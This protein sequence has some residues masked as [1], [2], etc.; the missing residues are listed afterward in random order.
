MDTSAILFQGRLTEQD[1]DVSINSRSTRR[2]DPSIEHAIDVLWDKALIQAKEHGF[3]LWDSG[4]YRVQACTF[5]N[6]RL[7]LALGHI[8]FKTGRMIQDIPNIQNMDEAYFPNSLSVV[9]IIKTADNRYLIGR[10]SS[11]YTTNKGQYKLIGGG[12]I[13]DEGEIHT[14]HDLFT[15]LTKELREEAGITQ[16][17]I[18]TMT[19]THIVRT[20]K[21]QIAIIFYLSLALDARDCLHQFKQEN[22][23]ELASLLCVP[24]HRLLYYLRHMHEYEEHFTPAISY[25]M[26]L[27]T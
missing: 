9:G 11:M 27:T 13:Q 7:Q 18:K 26:N 8:R 1:I 19:L 10:A 15:V 25:I 17:N 14:A 3:K 22:D 6:G 23:G 21:L 5:T 12:V 4:Q 20:K 24:Q 2:I 16:K